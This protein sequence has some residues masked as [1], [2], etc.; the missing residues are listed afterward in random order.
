MSDLI[1]EQF[2]EDFIEGSVETFGH[3]EVTREEVI[4]FASRYDPQPFHLSDEAAAQTFF[5]RMSASGWHT[6]AMTMAMMVAHQQAQ[7]HRGSGSPGVDELR[8][9]RPVYPGDVLSVRRTIL[10]K[11]RSAS[12]PG[13]GLFRSRIET[14]NQKGE[15]VLSFEGTAFVEVRQ[16]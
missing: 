10:N 16:P 14:L 12:R 1:A 8:F 15:V 13:L 9:L 6:A 2:F 11:R 4:A 3:T 7:G 5:G